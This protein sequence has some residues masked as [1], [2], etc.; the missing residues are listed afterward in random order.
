VS[1]TGS[2]CIQVVRYSALL[3][4]IFYGVAHHRT[5][6]NEENKKRAAHDAHKQEEL[7]QRAKDA[8][9][10]KKENTGGE[11]TYLFPHTQ[12]AR[13]RHSQLSSRYRPAY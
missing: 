2:R 1:N 13:V 11:L 3:S 4:G 12:V 7:L 9:K 8:W 6:Q 5:L 10:A